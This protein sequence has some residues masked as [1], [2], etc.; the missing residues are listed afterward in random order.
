M[1]TADDLTRL[2]KPPPADKRLDAAATPEAMR[3][4]TG[5]EG[6][7]RGSAKIKTEEITATSTDGLFTFVVT[8]LVP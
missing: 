2:V 1:S 6:L 4:K 7:N 3:D 5:L 8:V